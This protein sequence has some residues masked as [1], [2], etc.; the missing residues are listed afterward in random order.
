MFSGVSALP[1]S[2]GQLG[3]LDIQQHIVV[4]WKNDIILRA[5][6]FQRGSCANPDA[7]ARPFHQAACHQASLPDLTNASVSCHRVDCMLRTRLLEVAT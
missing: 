4:G 3:R 1:K 7:S 5:A 2:F 6:D